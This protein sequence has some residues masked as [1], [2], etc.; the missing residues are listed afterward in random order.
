MVDYFVSQTAQGTGSGLTPEN[1]AAIASYNSG[2][3]VFAFLG[4]DTVFLLGAITTQVTVRT[5]SAGS[6][7]TLRGDYSLDTQ[8]SIISAGTS[9]S[10]YLNDVDYVDIVGLIVL[11]GTLQGA[12]ANICNNITFENC[13]I[14]GPTGLYTN[15]CND[16]TI[17]NINSTGT[18][19]VNYAV[20]IDGASNSCTID[21]LTIPSSTGYG[22]YVNLSGSMSLSNIDIQD[23][24]YC[25]IRIGCSNNASIYGRDWYAKGVGQAGAGNVYGIWISGTGFTGLSADLKNINVEDSGERGLFLNGGTWTS[26]TLDTCRITGATADGI[27][28]ALINNW[29]IKNSVVTSSGLSGIRFIGGNGCT[30]QKTTVTDS[31]VDNISFDEN[32]IGH[33]VIGC[34]CSGAGQTDEVGYGDGI[35][36]HAGCTDL[37]IAMNVFHSNKNSGAAFVQSSSGVFL[38]NT[39]FNNGDITSVNMGVRGGFYYTPALSDGWEVKWNIIKDNLPY[40]IHLNADGLSS[41]TVDSNYYQHTDDDFCSVDGGSSA[42]T[43]DAYHATYEPNSV[44][45]NPLLI[46]TGKISSTSPCIDIGVYI[47]DVNMEGQA[48]PWGKKIYGLPN[49][50][51]DQG[52]GMP[53]SAR[54]TILDLSN[55]P[56]V[57]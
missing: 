6:I 20:R 34:I 17:K 40:E 8:G 11:P 44:Y 39:V 2:L 25:A 23:T 27:Y 5:G 26:A 3:G 51:A 48:D 21:G 43:W 50:G 4:G 32:S 35:T 24:Q 42:L 13:T 15:S 57:F 14:S 9:R 28:A 22:L 38:Y 55:N 36:A 31:G 7:H 45:T 46:G 53:R 16:L 47:A 54:S 41:I 1:A 52:A 29:T 10:L 37:I 18:S 33:T 12:Y 30:I 56:S 49:I 19:G